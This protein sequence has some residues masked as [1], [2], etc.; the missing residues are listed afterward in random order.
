LECNCCYTYDSGYDFLAGGSEDYQDLWRLTPTGCRFLYSDEEYGDLMSNLRKEKQRE[1]YTLQSYIGISLVDYHTHNKDCDSLFDEFINS[2]IEI[3]N[4]MLFRVRKWLLTKGKKRL[5]NAFVKK[6]KTLP[7]KEK[8]PS[9]EDFLK[10][11]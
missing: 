4:A 3:Q 11:L 7:T 9:I 5:M 1:N 2:T 10:T 6:L 8:S